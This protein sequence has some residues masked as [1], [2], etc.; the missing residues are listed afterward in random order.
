VLTPVRGVLVDLDDTLH[1]HAEFLDAAWR[2]VAEHGATR[3]LDPDALLG[4]LREETAAGATRPG[5][6][7]RA[8]ERIGASARHARPL[9]AAFRAVEPTGLAPYPGVRRALALLRERVPVAL[10]TDGHGPCER[11]KLAALGL[12]EAFDVVVFGDGQPAPLRRALAGLGLPA[13]A[14]VTVGNRP[15][16]DVA[17]AT[18][19]GVRAVRVC[20]GEHAVHPDHPRTWFRAPGFATAVRLLL[21]HLP[22][23]P[24]PIPAP[25]PADPGPATAPADPGPATAPADLAALAGP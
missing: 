25:R 13:E 17:Y 12:A 8:L 21:P 7:D 14:V 2:A 3:G 11:R 1:P 15:D 24:A 20:T 4:A 16:R 19:L 18:A 23:A 10:V 6:L 22:A 5:L 9:V